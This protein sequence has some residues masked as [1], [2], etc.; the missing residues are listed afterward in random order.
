MLSRGAFVAYRENQ[1][2][3]TAAEANA[4]FDAI[5]SYA[6]LESD[7]MVTEKQFED[8]F[9]LVATTVSEEYI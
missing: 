4:I 8:Y 1:G 3:S 9:V 5:T 2:T 6:E 7:S